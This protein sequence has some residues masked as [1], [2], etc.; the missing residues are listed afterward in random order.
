[1]TKQTILSDDACWA[2]LVARDKTADTLFVYAVKTTQTWG[3][4]STVVRLPK[5]ENTEFFATPEEAEAH[6]YRAGKRRQRSGEAMTQR[7][8]EQVVLACRELETRIDNGEPLPSLAE[9]ATLC[10]V[11]QFHF[12]RIFRSHTGLTP[13]AW[14][15][16]YRGDKLREQLTK[17]TTIT[18][19]IAE[20]GFSS[21]S[22]FYESSDTLLGMTPKSWR[23]GG[24]GARIFFALAIC[25]LGD[26]LV[27]QSEKGI[28]AILLGDDA[29]APSSGLDLPL[30]IRGTAF[31]RRVWQALQSIP[32]GTTVSYREIAERIGSPKAVRAVAGACAAN[33]LAVA[34]PCHR[35]VRTGGELA[36]YRWGI[37]RKKRLLQREALQQEIG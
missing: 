2:A 15:K 37:E 29:E 17:Q 18:G 11:S 4:P 24:K 13:A 33:C 26:I 25:A 27:A 28:C 23:A 9:L 6:G 22:R 12:H 32:A 35:V 14:A 7:H 10:G 31:Q 3:F 34:I 21:G 16:A 30:D 1:M 5:R 20:S 8:A 19:A 36:G